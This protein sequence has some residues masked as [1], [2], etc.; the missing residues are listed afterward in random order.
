MKN[1]FLPC[2]GSFAL[3]PYLDQEQSR[4]C[5]S[6][7]GNIE[8]HEL[9]SK[10]LGKREL[11]IYLPPG[12]SKYDNYAYPLALLQDGQNIFN[13]STA[14][15]GV[16]WGADETAEQLIVEQKM[17]PTILVAIYNSPHR[18]DEYT[19]FP[20]P[21]HGG[22]KASLYSRFLLEDVLPFLEERYAVTRQRSQR[23]VIGSSLGGLLALYLGWYRNETFGLI[24]A[25]SPSL[26]WGNR[27]LIT[28]IAGGERPQLP[29]RIWLDAGTLESEA[30][31]NQNGVP[32]LLD[33]LRTLR[34]V[35]RGH[36]FE[37]GV[38]LFYQEVEGATHDERSWSERIGQV[39]TSFFPKQNN[40]AR[41]Y[42]R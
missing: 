40:P 34:A 20:D 8:H 37:E 33:D 22:G 7:T 14:V 41:F 26:W 12:Y 28:A 9:H 17:E 3:R 35:L 23:A 4:R 39:F 29:L 11:V 31:A 25:L 19:P 36:G 5:G 38:H 30:D 2:Y 18:I 10:L 42:R 24:G 1:R 6:L 21:S 16:E 13:Q 27:G 15:F 32:D